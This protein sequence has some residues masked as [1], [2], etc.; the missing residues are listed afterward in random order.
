MKKL[1]GKQK[2]QNEANPNPE[3]KTTGDNPIP[4][5]EKNASEPYRGNYL[6][7]ETNI[8][9]RYKHPVENGSLY[10]FEFF[11][12]YTGEWQETELSEENIA[13]SVPT[14]DDERANLI[15]HIEDNSG[16]LSDIFKE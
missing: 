9:W 8:L 15:K 4:A 1:F 10:P 13:E 14:E 3:N 16:S 11:N 7:A 5:S 6:H 12:K 2:T